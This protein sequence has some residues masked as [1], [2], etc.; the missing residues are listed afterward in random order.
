MQKYQK[1]HTQLFLLLTTII[2]ATFFYITYPSKTEAEKNS[3]YNDKEITEERREKYV[4]VNLKTDTITTYNKG[5]TKIFNLV[6]QGKPGSYYE[7]IGGEY[8]SDYKEPLH[9]SSIGHVYMPYSIHIFGNYFIHG[10]PYHE[11]GTKVSSA[12]SGGCVRVGDLDAEYLYDFID[13]K[14]PIII[15]QGNKDDFIPTKENKEDV[16]KIKSESMTRLMVATISLEILTQDNEII[17][18]DGSTT[19]RK[20]ILKRL[21]KNKD[22]SVTEIYEEYFGE[23]YF[24]ETMNKK[25][26]ILGLTNTTFKDNISAA[27]TTKED[28]ERFTNYIKIYKSFLLKDFRE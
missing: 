25:A 16:E 14:T 8:T 18:I 7:T 26:K 20:T 17:D 9:F 13:K 11:D 10:I 22:T 19:T 24:V 4:L 28:L 23:N 12:Y 2:I 21:L 27:E 6:S 15:T 1:K 3:P 5:V